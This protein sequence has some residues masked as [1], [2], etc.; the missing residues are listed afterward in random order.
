MRQVQ[1]CLLF[2]GN[3]GSGKSTIRSMNNL[4]SHLDH[5]DQLVVIDNSTTDG[6][7]ILGAD[8]SGVKYYLDELPEW[9][10]KIDRQLQNR[11]RTKK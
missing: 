5:I 11:N 7:I 4:L 1:P 9:T 8:N 10:Q 3:N 2:A 6:E